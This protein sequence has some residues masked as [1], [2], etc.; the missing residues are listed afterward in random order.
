MSVAPSTSKLC[1]TL[2]DLIELLTKYGETGWSEHLQR[3]LKRVEKH[4]A[5]GFEDL[6][7]I[8]GGMG[9]FS[10]LILSPVNGHDICEDD[11]YPVNRRL[12]QL[13]SIAYRTADTLLREH[14]KGQS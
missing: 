13:R 3:I 9:S 8:Y 11:V 10:D 12:E 1:N 2:T 6:L 5:R 7:G 4:Q 14:K